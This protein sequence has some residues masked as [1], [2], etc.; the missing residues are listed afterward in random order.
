MELD[1]DHYKLVADFERHFP[2]GPPSL[3]GCE[4]LEVEGEVGFGR[5]VVVRGRVRLSGPR[6]VED[7]ALLEG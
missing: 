7:G 2:S 3:K 4:R 1:P 5:D 6:Q